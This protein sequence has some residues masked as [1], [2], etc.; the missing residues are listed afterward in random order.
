MSHFLGYHEFGRNLFKVS[1]SKIQFSVGLRKSEIVRTLPEIPS[2][3][4]DQNFSGSHINVC[5]IMPVPV[6][7]IDLEHAEK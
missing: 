7:D 5:V 6:W 2:E 3:D 1:T 4:F